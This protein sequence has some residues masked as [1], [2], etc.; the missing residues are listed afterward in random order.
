MQYSDSVAR[1][2]LKIAEF[3]PGVAPGTQLFKQGDML[4][5]YYVIVRGTV[6]IEQ[7]AARY[8]DKKDMLPIVVRTCY[9]G[10]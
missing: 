8:K 1:K 2:L 7:I 4:D 5:G 6:K 10:D 9:D 3:M